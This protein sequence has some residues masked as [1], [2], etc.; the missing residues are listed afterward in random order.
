MGKINIWLPHITDEV[1]N[2][3]PLRM[4]RKD[5]HNGMILWVYKKTLILTCA[6][7]SFKLINRNSF[8]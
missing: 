4:I 6:G 5:I 1:F 8:F 7:I 3:K 2:L